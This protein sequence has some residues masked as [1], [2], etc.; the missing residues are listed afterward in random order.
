M[1]LIESTVVLWGSVLVAGLHKG[2][3]QQ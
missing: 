3:P 1:L 2:I